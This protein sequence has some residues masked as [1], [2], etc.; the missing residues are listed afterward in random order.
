MFE[1]RFRIVVL[2]LATA[3]LSMMLANILTL[4]FTIICMTEEKY[5][6][7]NFTI[8]LGLDVFEKVDFDPPKP[9]E[10]KPPETDLPDIPIPDFDLPGIRIPTPGLNWQSLKLAQHNP[11]LFFKIFK[12]VLKEVAY[13]TAVHVGGKLDPRNIDFSKLRDGFN[14]TDFDPNVVI[15]VKDYVL[16][17]VE[18]ARDTWETIDA[19]GRNVSQWRNVRVEDIELKNISWDGT[20]R[21]RVRILDK[22]ADHYYSSAEKAMLFSVIA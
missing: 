2:I 11:D 17:K 7:E 13:R 19:E 15:R 3:C 8:D 4:T 18:L 1:G 20:I 16:Q 21:G 14:L 12:K 5:R 22:P 10:E 6:W 9:S